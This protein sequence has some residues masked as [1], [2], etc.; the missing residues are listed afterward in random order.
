[1]SSTLDDLFLWFGGTLK[2]P[3][4]EGL[5]PQPGVLLGGALR[6]GGL[7][8]T[9]RSLGWRLK[10]DR[11]ILAAT[12]FR[13]TACCVLPSRAASLQ[14]QITGPSNLGPNPQNQEPKEASPLLD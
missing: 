8:E 2:G 6:S 12:L 10:E 13:G 1:M 4:A 5:G 3:C 7:G 9:V 11:V 14:V